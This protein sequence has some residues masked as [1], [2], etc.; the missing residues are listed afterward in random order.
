MAQ[1]WLK[2]IMAISMS[3]L[4]LTA[5][6]NSFC[7]DI[8]KV[9]KEKPEQK[10]K[11][12]MNY[13][14]ADQLLLSLKKKS[15]QIFKT[16]ENDPTNQLKTLYENYLDLRLALLPSEQARNIRKLLAEHFNYTA[17]SAAIDGRYISDSNSISVSIPARYAN[18]GL[19]FAIRVH[20]LEHAIQYL[21]IGA[22]KKPAYPVFHPKSFS[23]FMFQSE[24]AAMT[25]ESIFLLALPQE[26]KRNLLAISHGDPEI[27]KN[28]KKLIDKMLGASLTSKL[29]EEYVRSQWQQWRY[30]R[31]YFSLLQL[32]VSAPLPFLGFFA[33]LVFSN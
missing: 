11:T 2:Y 33:W 14:I 19:D 15:E 7:A 12:L 13:E 32:G 21:S 10:V 27:V 18:T 30:S 22:D 5:M 17:K 9:V 8:F 4:P 29:P 20:E 6:A 24:K 28:D 26:Y 31:T 25:A 3:L 16:R 1:T 23:V